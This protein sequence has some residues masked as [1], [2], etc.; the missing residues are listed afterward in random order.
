MI[1]FICQELLGIFTIS[2][3]LCRPQTSL[4]FKPVSGFKRANPSLK[5]SLYPQSV[6]YIIT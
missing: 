4:A 1:L 6:C 5:Q 2:H 3:E